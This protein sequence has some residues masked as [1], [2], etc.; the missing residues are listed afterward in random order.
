M[1]QRI[2]TLWMLLAA[3]CAALTFKFPF[4]S[5]NVVVG[6]NGHLFRS[7]TAAR[8][9][10]V[11]FITVILIVGILFNIISYKN[12]R[13]QIWIN[14]GLIVV[15]LLNIFLYYQESLNYIEGKVALGAI[16]SIVIPI[17]LILAV[18]GIIRDNKLVKSADRLR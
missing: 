1:L 6:A 3:V 17:L 2:Q 10:T 13:R 15:S 14:I 18:R 9:V 11:L 16:L 8:S 5:G 7:L 12:R 4:F